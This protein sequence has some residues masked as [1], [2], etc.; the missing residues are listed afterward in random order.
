VKAHFIHRDVSASLGHD[1]VVLLHPK[2]RHEL[3]HVRAFR[4]MVVKGLR[5]D[6]PRKV[7]L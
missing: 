3:A 4:E 7:A 6:T 1:Q 5:A 2:G